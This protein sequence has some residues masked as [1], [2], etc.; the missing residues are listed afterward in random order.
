MVWYVRRGDFLSK[1]GRQQEVI[2]EEE[3]EFK[4]NLEWEEAEAK[5]DATF[6][7]FKD[8]FEDH[9]LGKASNEREGR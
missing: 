5:R 7:E 6:E 9:I 8:L 3:A 1:P 2:D 4:L